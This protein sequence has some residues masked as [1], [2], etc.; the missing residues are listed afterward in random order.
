MILIALVELGGAG[1]GAD[2]DEVEGIEPLGF[3][4][5]DSFPVASWGVGFVAIGDGGST[6]VLDGLEAVSGCDAAHCEGD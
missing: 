1:A 3:G 5:I 4:V 6:G 2:P